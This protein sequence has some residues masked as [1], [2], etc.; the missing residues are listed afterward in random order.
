MEVQR[1]NQVDFSR[2]ALN[3]KLREFALKTDVVAQ[4]DLFS[5]LALRNTNFSFF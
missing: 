3:D 4:S 2:M 1:G 5:M